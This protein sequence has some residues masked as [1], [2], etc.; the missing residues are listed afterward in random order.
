MSCTYQ[1]RIYRYRAPPLEEI[2]GNDVKGNHPYCK[3]HA[4]LRERDFRGLDTESWLYAIRPFPEDSNLH[5]DDFSEEIF[6]EYEEYKDY[7]DYKATDDRVCNDDWIHTDPSTPYSQFKDELDPSRY[8]MPDFGCRFKIFE[9][10]YRGVYCGHHN[11]DQCSYCPF[12]ESVNKLPSYSSY[13]VPLWPRV[14][15]PTA[16]DSQLP[17]DCVNW[18]AYNVTDLLFFDMTYPNH[19]NVKRAK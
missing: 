3:F 12:H 19:S 4:S 15:L 18:R 7:C 9:G 16:H 1:I 2:C 6:E 5:Y 10:R 8:K 14:I 11:K 17:V 13:P